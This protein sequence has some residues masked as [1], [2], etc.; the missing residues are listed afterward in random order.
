MLEKIKKI[1]DNYPA[2]IAYEINNHHITYQELWNR[3]LEYATFLKKQGNSPV[4]IYDDKSINYL[5]TILACLLAKRAYVPLSKQVP[6]NRLLKIIDI[7]NT[8][9]IITE[10]KLDIDNIECCRLNDL[11]NYQERDNYI[12]DNEIAYIIFTSGSTDVPKGVP[13]TYDN[14][15]NFIN[16]MGHIN[17]LNSY[18]HLKVLEQAHFSFDLSVADLYYALCYGHT[19]VSV[20]YNMDYQDLLNNVQKVNVAFITPTFINLLLIDK[21]FNEHNFANLKCLYFC[22]EMLQVQT[23]KKLYERFPHLSIINAYGPTEATSAVS[24]INITSDMLNNKLLP[25]GDMNNVATKI[26]IE[27]DKIVLKGNSVFKGYLGNIKG[28]YYQEDGI[29]CFNTGDIGYIEDN[30]LYCKGRGDSQIKYKGYRIELNEIEYYINSIEGVNNCCVLAKYDDN[31][32]VTLIK[33]YVEVEK[34]IDIKEELKKYLPSYM[35]P[36][37]IKIMNKLPI[38]NNGKIDRKALNNL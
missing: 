27:D 23:V 21:S 37:V 25:V 26:V 24:A 3:A 32:V 6:I 10:S 2:L 29:D 19:L 34:N 12:N 18:Q 9:L 16:W 20:D 31:Q 8:T 35:I 15:D 11:V 38:N 5:I 28:G 33:A 1:V 7:T 22:G 13:I 17:P 30:R 14:L 4:I 36:K